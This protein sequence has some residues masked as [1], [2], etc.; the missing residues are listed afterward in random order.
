MK[1]EAKKPQRSRTFLQALL[2][3]AVAGIAAIWAATAFESKAVGPS[4]HISVID[5]DTIQLDGKIVQLYGIDAPELGQ[6]CL[7]NGNLGHC[8]LS[9]AFELQKLLK[10]E[11]APL[12]CQPA[13]AAGN[14]PIQICAFGYEDPALILLESG[15]GLAI[16]GAGPK[17][18]KAEDSAKQVRI[19]L[20]HNQ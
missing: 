11:L 2:V 19:G 5:G 9:A 8:G 7:H 13:K 16:A 3:L 15:Y 6:M 17:Y 10:I 20:W 14:P 1:P 12:T 4:Q 18:A